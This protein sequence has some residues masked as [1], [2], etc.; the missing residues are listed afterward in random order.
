MT[1]STDCSKIIV[2]LEPYDSVIK[3]NRVPMSSSTYFIEEEGKFDSPKTMLIHDFIPLLQ[4]GGVEH[5]LVKHL[6][7]VTHK[8]IDNIVDEK[9][10]YVVRLCASNFFQRQKQIGFKCVHPKTLE[11]IRNNQCKMI[12]IY[13]DEGN[14]GLPRFADSFSILQDWCIESNLPF[15]NVYFFTGN[16]KAQELFGHTVNYNIVC[17]HNWD[18]LNDPRNYSMVPFEPVDNNCLYVNLN[19]SRYK[20]R[21][22]MLIFLIKENL[23]YRGLNSFNYENEEVIKLFPDYIEKIPNLDTYC[24][25]L[26]LIGSNVLDHPHTNLNMSMVVNT[27]FYRKT[28]CSIIPESHCESETIHFSEK[29]WKPI[30]NGH[31]FMLLTSPGQL[32]YLKKLGFKT[33]S[34]WFDES[35]DNCDDLLDRV[36]IITSNLK[37]YENHSITDLIKIRQDMHKTIEYNYHHMLDMYKKKYIFDD[38]KTVT[39]RK[40]HLDKLLEILENWN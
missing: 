29:T 26:E 3:T 20:H 39:G 12:I 14:Q 40:P 1:K 6:D 13:T 21:A 27:D 23:L 28:F 5:H 11:H 2:G 15:E 37:R 35:Y 36:K 19:R 33:Y 32:N 25:A 16:M 9:Y 17:M 30:M 18:S 34:D 22:L 38:H 10:F 8:E 24:R 4:T 31:P 7:Y